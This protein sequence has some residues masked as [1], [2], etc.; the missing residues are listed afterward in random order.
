[1]TKIIPIGHPS[2][3]RA[4]LRA[5]FEYTDGLIA[6]GLVGEVSTW[7]HTPL[8]TVVSLYDRDDE[9]ICHIIKWFRRYEV[10]S[11]EGNLIHNAPLLCDVLSV[12]PTPLP[13]ETGDSAP[14]HSLSRSV[15][16]RLS[17]DR[18]VAVSQGGQPGRGFLAHS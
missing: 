4:D 1:M 12:L 7:Q 13:Q 16:G 2:M 11:G 15:N 8:G 18:E 5:I 9:L 3:T 6:E 17:E 14:Q 10:R